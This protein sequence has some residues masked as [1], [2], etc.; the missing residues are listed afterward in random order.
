[1]KPYFL[2]KK[3]KTLFSEKKKKKKKKKK[4]WQK[5]K[6]KQETKLSAEFLTNVVNL[7]CKLAKWNVNVFWTENFHPNRIR[8]FLDDSNEMPSF[9]FK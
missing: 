8:Q 1:M 7:K 5:T 9:L 6:K 4:N 2:K 3:K